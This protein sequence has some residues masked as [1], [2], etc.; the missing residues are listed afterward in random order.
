MPVT[1]ICP[2]CNKEFN[3]KPSHVKSR[4]YCS[5]E[6]MSKGNTKPRRKFNCLTCGKEVEVYD[7]KYRKDAKFCGNEC[8]GKYKSGENHWNFKHGMKHLPEDRKKCHERYYKRNK[9]AIQRR[10]FLSKAKRRAMTEP[11]HTWD[12]WIELLKKHDNRCY[13][14]NCKMTKTAGKRQRTRDHIIPLTKGGKDTIENIVP[15][16]RS[17]NSSKGVKDV[18]EFMNRK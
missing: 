11:A 13:Y 8:A 6:C 18:D 17:C 15:A 5:R 1:L 7:N 12:E 3:V 2:Q 4:K 10:L 14:C 9:E 16:C